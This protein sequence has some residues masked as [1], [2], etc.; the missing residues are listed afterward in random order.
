MSILEKGAPNSMKYLNKK[1]ILHYIKENEGASRAEI[2]SILEISKPTVSNLVDELL[3]EGLVTE[4][5]SKSASAMGGRKP[6][7]LYFNKMAKYLVGID[8]GGT[9]IEM[10]L[11]NLDGEV[12]TQRT[13]QTSRCRDD[14]ILK[15]ADQVEQMLASESVSRSQ[16]MAVG[17]GVPGITDVE[18]GIVFE[19][20]S[21]GWK[22]YPLKKIL[23]E[24]LQLP[25]YIDNDVNVALLGEQWKGVAQNKENIIYI[26]LGTG[27][28]CG[29]MVNGEI[30]HGS[31]YAAGEIGYMVT[32]KQEAQ[33]EYEPTFEGYGFLDSHVG[34]PALVKR[35][36]K[37]LEQAE[38]KL[39]AADIEA[40]TAESI[41]ARAKMND[42]LALK[43]VN[44]FVEHL[45]F[46]IVNVVAIFN[47]QCVVLSGGLSRSGEWFLPRL[48][49]L[50]NKYLPIQ[51][52]IE[53]TQLP[54]APLIG[55]ASLCL[56]SHESLLKY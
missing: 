10:G 18:K 27:V 54:Y 16:I 32:D 29:I 21:L 37:E 48:R 11:L 35:M 2:S 17:V 40:L 23:Q 22:Q 14:I 38:I 20:P 6:I 25:V 26:A 31:T 4:S 9:N 43:V 52:E 42:E 56:R 7:Q 47:P 44:E 51:P 30:Y 3:V 24:V 55:A 8:I 33:N 19:A 1:K 34:G 45:G 28:G 53:L 5:M 39:S 49:G 15:I 41:F 50:A 13:F 12:V 36:K 46:A